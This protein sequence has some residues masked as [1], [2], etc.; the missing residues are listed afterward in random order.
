MEE[1]ER[2]VLVPAGVIGTT[3]SYSKLARS[4]TGAVLA[5][6]GCPFRLEYE[7][8]LEVDAA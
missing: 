4:A 2:V 3:N 7:G 1:R 8:A 6:R 5:R